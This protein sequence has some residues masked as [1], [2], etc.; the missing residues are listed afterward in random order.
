MGFGGGGRPE[1]FWPGGFGPALLPLAGPL[2]GTLTRDEV[3]NS[4]Y[5]PITM[6]D[7]SKSS[8]MI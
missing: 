3:P 1:V 6:L 8:N 2:G 5:Q 4:L 7:R